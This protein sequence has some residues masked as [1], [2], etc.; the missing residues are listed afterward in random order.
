MGTYNLSNY[1]LSVKPNDPVLLEMFGVFSIGGEGS[2]VNSI[3][4]SRSTN[5]FSVSGYATGG[6]VISKSLDRTGSI[7]VSLS[8]L[9][10]N[11]GRFIKL[12]KAYQG[13]DY[14]GFTLTLSDLT[15]KKVVTGIDCFLNIPEQSF[16]QSASD[17]TWSFVCG[18]VNFE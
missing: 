5:M 7:S 11:V 12:M 17:Q 16:G 8:Q 18:Q 2:T 1:I 10:T 15:G 4:A 3:S 6:Y 13:G 9:A 14:E